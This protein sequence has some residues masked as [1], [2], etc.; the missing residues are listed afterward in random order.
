MTGWRI[1]YM[2]GNKKIAEKV[3]IVQSHSTSNPCSISQAA[4]ECALLSDMRDTL[5]KSA[6][7]FQMRRDL[8]ISLFKGENTLAPLKPEGAFYLFI[9]ISRTGLDSFTFC[10]RLLEENGV[11][12]IPGQPFGEDNYVRLSFAASDQDI[13]E[14]V[15]RIREFA[16]SLE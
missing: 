2:A 4:S 16:K 14:G 8:L 6:S 3:S 9:D 7:L 11:A 13:R 10:D 15:K 5:R 1:G 12:I